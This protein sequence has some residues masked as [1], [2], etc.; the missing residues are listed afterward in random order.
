MREGE[1]EGMRAVSARSFSSYIQVTGFHS[2][3]FLS[4]PLLVFF[5]QRLTC[6]GL[7]QSS[8]G[9][10]DRSEGG[11]VRRGGRVG[12]GKACFGLSDVCGK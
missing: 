10:S 4:I 5:H 11:G 7:R 8:S 2:S 6:S 12:K 1:D 3:P 9:G